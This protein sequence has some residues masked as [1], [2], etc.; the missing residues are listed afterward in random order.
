[1]GRFRDHRVP[2]SNVRVITAEIAGTEGP[3]RAFPTFEFEMRTSRPFASG[4]RCD[5]CDGPIEMRRLR[6]SLRSPRS[7]RFNS[8][9][10]V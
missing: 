2:G 8:L 3:A 4:I 10:P 9:A 7:L 5:D 6:R 1:M